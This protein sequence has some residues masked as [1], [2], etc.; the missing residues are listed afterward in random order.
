M[1]W[2]A[3]L[4]IFSSRKVKQKFKYELYDVIKTTENKPKTVTAGNSIINFLKTHI[5]LNFF[6]FRLENRIYK[7]R[8]IKRNGNML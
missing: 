1:L 4:Y 8:F 3:V 5:N 7:K 2:S 6:L